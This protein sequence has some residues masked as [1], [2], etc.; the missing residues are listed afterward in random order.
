MGNNV[1]STSGKGNLAAY[2]HDVYD[3]ET[4]LYRM[5]KLRDELYRGKA[6]FREA[7]KNRHDLPAG[8][9]AHHRTFQHIKITNQRMGFFLGVILF[10]RNEINIFSRHQ[11]TDILEI[12]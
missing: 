4:R 5:K 10:H 11:K 12:G 7:S 1:V 3:V 8:K 2:V 6:A 9:S